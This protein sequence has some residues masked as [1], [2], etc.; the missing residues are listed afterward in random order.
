[1]IKIKISSELKGE[2]VLSAI[3]SKLRPG[4]VVE[5][6][7]E[8]A[9]DADVL[10]AMKK[11]YISFNSASSKSAEASTN[12]GDQVEFINTMKGGVTIPFLGRTISAQQR[13]ILKRGDKNM[14]KAMKIVEA[15]YLTCS[16][17]PAASAAP[18]VVQEKKA[19]KKGTR[20]S[21]IIKNSAG[22]AEKS[23]EIFGLMNTEV[24]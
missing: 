3:K 12:S 16:D 1:M 24:T 21:F 22:E 8:A 23:A 17:V 5:I 7:E 11:G 9:A 4:S 15:G 14:E 18:A 13:F 20:K 6:S 2:L 19:P 10:W